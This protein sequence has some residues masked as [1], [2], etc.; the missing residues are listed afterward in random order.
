MMSALIGILW[1]VAMLVSI[2]LIYMTWGNAMLVQMFPEGRKWY[3]MPSRLASLAVF[4][5]VVHFH[6]FV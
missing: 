1:F 2:G 3:D 5:A 6:P 4:A